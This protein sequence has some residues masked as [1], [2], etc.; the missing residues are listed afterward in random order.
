M[1]KTH[2]SFFL[3]LVLLIGFFP[4]MC[5]AVTES[6]TIST[7]IDS[8]TISGV[9]ITFSGTTSLANAT[10]YLILNTTTIAKITADT[11]GNWSFTYN[12]LPDGSY[13][14][15]AKVIDSSFS[16][17]ATASCSFTV[18]NPPKITVTHPAQDEILSTLLPATI[19]GF[20]SV[21]SGWVQLYMDTLFTN[22]I[23]TDINGNWQSNYPALVN[24][25]H[26][27]L[28]ELLTAAPLEVVADTN[29]TFTSSNPVTFASGI[30][31]IRLL[32]GRIPTSGSGSGPGFTYS[33]SGSIITLIFSPAFPSIPYVIATGH[34]VSGTSTV[35][36]TSVTTTS[37]SIA[38]STGTQQVSFQATLLQ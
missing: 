18:V 24:G 23:S 3:I 26:T 12:D 7:P 37:A 22:T 21:A 32:Q 8:S 2:I 16:T 13:T 31:L 17:L 28:V 15:T 11:G 36:I 29:V 6:I 35:T 27:L 4:S 38:F 20:S 19:Q 25:E 34:R 30:S 10:I 33:V 14:C 9:S 5:D 1:H